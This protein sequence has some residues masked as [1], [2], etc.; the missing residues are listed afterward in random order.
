MYFSEA[1]FFLLIFR[2]VADQL[3]IN[4]RIVDAKLKSSLIIAGGRCL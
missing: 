4:L 3:L 1:F 2:L